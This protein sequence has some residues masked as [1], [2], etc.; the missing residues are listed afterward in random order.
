MARRKGGGLNQPTVHDFITRVLTN[1]I[2]RAE[3]PMHLRLILQPLVACYFA[4]RAGLRDVRKNNP[5]FLWSLAFDSGHRVDLL[6]NGWKDIGKLFGG[7]VILDVVYQVIELRRV[8][9][10][11]AITVA[12]LLAVLPYF[13]LRA[14]VRRL[15]RKKA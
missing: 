10:G 1:L 3:G 7:A 13:I 6:R 8:Y 2:G 12:V 4:I 11:E 5:P 15:A 14:A 9:P